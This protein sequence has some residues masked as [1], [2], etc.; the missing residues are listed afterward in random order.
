MADRIMMNGEIIKQPLKGLGYKFAKKYSSDST[1]VQSGRKH[2]TTIGTYEEFTYSAADLTAS[3]LST[4]LHHIIDGEVFVLHY[5]S[6]Y[7][8]EWRDGEFLV[9]SADVSIGRWI[10]KDERYESLSFTMTGVNPLD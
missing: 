1:F 2:T 6:P 9:E 8:G 3:E 7:Y 10:E 4:I 5:L